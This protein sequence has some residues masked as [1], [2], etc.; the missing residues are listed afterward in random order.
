MPFQVSSALLD[1]VLY[2][3]LGDTNSDS[4]LSRTSLTAWNC[5]TSYPGRVGT[6]FTTYPGLHYNTD[7]DS[8]TTV[9]QRIVDD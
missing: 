3:S 7:S 1:V 8:I 9:L 5:F 2:E 6:P 4:A